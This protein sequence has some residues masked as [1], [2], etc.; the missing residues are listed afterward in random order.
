[1]MKLLDFQS[2]KFNGSKK[3]SCELEKIKYT[4][5]GFITQLQNKLPLPEK[6]E[7]KYNLRQ[8]RKRRGRI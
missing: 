7:R 2:S 6:Q 5:D 3:Q 1:M 8:R 4:K